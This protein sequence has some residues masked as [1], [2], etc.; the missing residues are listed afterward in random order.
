MSDSIQSPAAD[1]AVSVSIQIKKRDSRCRFWAKVI[2]AGQ[3]LPMPSAVS[4]AN[5]IPGPFA[6]Q[7]DEELFFGDVLIE[8]E[9]NHH[10]HARGWTYWV[11]FVGLDG[12]VHVVQPNSEIKAALKKAG[13]DRALLAGSGDVAACVRIA[14][15]LRAGFAAWVVEPQYVRPVAPRIEHGRALVLVV[16]PGCGKTRM[17]E[18]L[19]EK[20]F[21]SIL[22][23]ELA[24]RFQPWGQNTRTVI[25]EGLPTY[26]SAIERLKTWISSDSMKLNRIL[27]EPVEM[28]TPN[29]IICAQSGTIDFLE[30]DRRFRVVH[31]P[32]RA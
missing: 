27:K 31:L 22:A 19:A 2:R 6:Q 20:P 8:G 4:G 13:L 17:A 23:D 12:A 7:G 11:T 14:H 26:R 24:D 9:E 18:D 21:V 16:P 5:D 28:R 1:A 29:F 15:G 3:A 30:E 32:P 10:R 25:V